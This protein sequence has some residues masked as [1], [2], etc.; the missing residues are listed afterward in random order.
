MPS[1]RKALFF[2]AAGKY[3]VSGITF[4]SIVVLAR[5][6]TPEEIGIYS[7]GA[8]LVSLTHVLRQFG[9]SDYIA[10]RSECTA[11][12]LRGCQG[13]SILFAWSL[14][15]ALF[16]SSDLIAALYEEPRLAEVIAVSAIS[17]FIAPLGLVPLAMLRRSMRFDVLMRVN[18]LQVA[19]GATTTI[20]LA[21]EDFGPVSMAWGNVANILTVV[22]ALML[23]KAEGMWV[24]PS[25]E[26]WRRILGYGTSVSGSSI[27]N[28]AGYNAPDMIVSA[29]LG[30]A[31]LGLFSRANGLIK[32]FNVNVRQAVMP[33]ALPALAKYKRAGKSLEPPYINGVDIYCALAIPFFVCLGVRRSP[34]FWCCSGSSGWGP[35]RWFPSSASARPLPVS[36]VSSDRFFSLPTLRVPC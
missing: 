14:G 15:L 29:T 6:L 18:V 31:P 16:A 33:V 20:V 1:I 12:D 25:W 5:L 22:P 19:V 2:S 30:F 21:L 36:P 34:S 10:S 3:L 13:V 9:I 27:I 35:C 7:A 26:N 28:E 17:F 11:A 32:M 4:V 23:M 8:A 24:P